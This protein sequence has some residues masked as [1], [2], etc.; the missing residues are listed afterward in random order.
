MF[1]FRYGQFRSLNTTMADYIP[2]VRY[3]RKSAN[4][5]RMQF[6]LTPH[7]AKYFIKFHLSRWFVFSLLIYVAFNN[8]FQEV[9]F[10]VFCSALYAE[11]VNK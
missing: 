2:T 3:H 9:A 8:I 7:S 1:L 6:L 10:F 5:C 4:T 11:K